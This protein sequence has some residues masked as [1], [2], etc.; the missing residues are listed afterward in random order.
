[1]TYKNNILPKEL[2]YNNFSKLQV[3]TV[4]RQY[5]TEMSLTLEKKSDAMSH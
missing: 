1:M 5:A 4:Y 3:P 2:A